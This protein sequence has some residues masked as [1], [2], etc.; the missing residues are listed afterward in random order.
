MEGGSLADGVDGEYGGV[1]F[2]E[3]SQ[4][5]ATWYT[6]LYETGAFDGV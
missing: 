1:Y 3:I 5:F 4:I 6:F 2:V